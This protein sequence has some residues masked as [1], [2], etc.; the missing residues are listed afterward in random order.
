MTISILSL[1]GGFTLTSMQTPAKNPLTVPSRQLAE[2]IASEWEGQERFLAAK[3][4]LTSL[5]YTAIDRIA[6]QREAVVE[7][8]LVFLDTDTLSYRAEAE[9]VSLLADQTKGW[10]PILVWAKERFGVTWQVTS[11]IMP[12]DQSPELH[13]AI[14]RYLL[15]L[16]AMHVA[17]LSVF[18]TLFS[19]LAL[20]IA[21][22][23]RHIDAMQGFALSRLE[24][25][26]QN[27][28]W[29]KDEE[30]IKRAKRVEEETYAVSRF[31]NAL[32]SVLDATQNRH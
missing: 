25:E 18:A 24:E 5:A 16:D 9:Q 28:R 29:G 23:D 3:M 19:S 8:L 1:D 10:D 13:A 14:R 2:A 21:V 15:E 32:D 12:I 31:L 20:A 27:A 6:P 7:S 11:G 30:A 22:M 4:P 17:A 26:D